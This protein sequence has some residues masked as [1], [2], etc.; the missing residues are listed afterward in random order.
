MEEKTKTITQ[1]DYMDR[2]GGQAGGEIELAD[3]TVPM[4]KGGIIV[5][6]LC[7]VFERLPD[8]ECRQ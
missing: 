8:V 3:C 6:F 1:T 7:K 5:D 2:S 4:H